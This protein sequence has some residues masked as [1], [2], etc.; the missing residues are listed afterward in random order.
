MSLDANIFKNFLINEM[1]EYNNEGK[2][3]NRAEGENKF[4]LLSQIL[5]DCNAVIAGGSVLSAY[6][7]SRSRLND[8]DVYVNKK[9]A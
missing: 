5:K 6:V 2:R 7:D 1:F 9:N 4:N 3:I 8:I